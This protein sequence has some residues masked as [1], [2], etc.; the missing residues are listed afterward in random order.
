MTTLMMLTTITTTTTVPMLLLLLDDRA[1][2]KA[3]A[4]PPPSSAALP[5]PLSR[6]LFLSLHTAL[7][8]PIYAPELGA[9]HSKAHSPGLIVTI[10]TK[11]QWCMTG[12]VDYTAAI[13]RDTLCGNSRRSHTLLAAAAFAVRFHDDP[14]DDFALSALEFLAILTGGSSHGEKQHRVC[15]G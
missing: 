6:F 4:C 14:H 9:S 5:L 2:A 15:V 1:T 13:L 8:S 7:S 10:A 12:R 11:G 3:F